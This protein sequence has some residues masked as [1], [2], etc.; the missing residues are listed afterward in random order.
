M[1]KALEQIE[2][3]IKKL[4][5]EQLKA[6]RAWYA[7]FDSDAWDKQIE[8]DANAGKLQSLAATALRDHQAGRSREL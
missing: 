4:G 2:R 5:P 1:S 7:E 3:D 8:V 6:F